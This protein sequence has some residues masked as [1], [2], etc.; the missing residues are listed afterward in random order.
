LKGS[1]EIVDNSAVRI[2]CSTQVAKMIECYIEKSEVLDTT[3]GV[4]DVIVYWGLDEMQRLARIFPN[5]IKV[6]SPIERDYEWPGMFQPF[7]HQRDTSRFLS[8]HRR[9]FCFNEAGTGKTS[10]AIWAADYLMNQGKVRRALVICPLSIMHSAWQADLF[11][12][13]MHRTCAVAHGAT[14]KREKIIRSDYQFVIINYDG[15][16]VVEKAIAEGK[17]DLIIVDEANAYKNTATRRWKTLARLVKPDTYLWMMTG[18]PAAQS[19]EDA[20]GLAR[21]VNPDGVPRYKTAWRDK[22]MS[23]VTRFKWSPKPDSRVTVFDALQPAIRYEKAQCLD[24]PDVVYQ[25]RLVPLSPQASKYYR[26]LVKEM[27]IK[28]AGETISTVNAAASLTR[29][30]Q[31]SGGAVYTDDGNVVEFDITPRLSVLQEVLDEAMHK[32]LIFIPYKHT[33]SLVQKHL[34]SAGISNEIISGDVTAI[35]RADVFKNFQ[36]NTDPRVLLIQPQAASHGV[37]LTAADTVI[38][39]SPVMSVETYLQCIARIDRVGQKNSMT[40][41]HLQGSEVERRMYTMLQNKVSLHEKLVDLYKDELE[42][43]KL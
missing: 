1:M 24:L 32:V 23:Q 5:S 3:D 42:G 25:T 11:K 31:L 17:F 34:E 38:F 20:F 9:A 40:V 35:Q 7:D 14:P 18:T 19:P 41:I 33:L 37:T 28:T 6:P 29:L 39:W 21:L 8:V 30:L 27:Q 2:Q 26:D 12:T 36:Q 10:A 16:G 13:A 22:V 15:V 4:S 43:E